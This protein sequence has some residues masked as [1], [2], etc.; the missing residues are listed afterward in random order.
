MWLWG[1]QKSCVEQTVREKGHDCHDCGSV[2]FNAFEAEWVLGGELRVFLECSDCEAEDDLYL[3]P[4]EAKR[5]GFDPRANL[6]DDV[7]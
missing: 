2:G 4:E 5:C 3:S 6:P 1:E 7:P